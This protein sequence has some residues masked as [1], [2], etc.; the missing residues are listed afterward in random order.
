MGPP[1]P[2]PEVDA[3]YKPYEGNWKCDTTFQAGA[4]GPG[5]P[6]MTAKTEVKIKR[7]PSGFW[8]RGE[9]KMKKT[10]STPEMGGMFLLGYDEA[11]KA[12][13]NLNFDNMGG[14]A[15]EHASGATA[16][17]IPFVGDGSMMGMKVKFRETMS[18]KDSKTIE[19]E[20]SADMGKGF[21]PLGLDVCKK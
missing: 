11:A 5:S 20:F 9:Y 18:Q 1:K 16:E 14:Y 15:V 10:K 6:G 8:Y 7:D 17:K 21:Q 2:S 3:L 19:H 4:F 12:P 13:V